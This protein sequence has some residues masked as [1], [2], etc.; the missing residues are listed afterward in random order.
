MHDAE[1]RALRRAAILLV[2]ISAAR[3]GW[4][5]VAGPPLG[6]DDESVLE[7][8]A[9]AVDDAVREEERRSAPLADG[10]LID[11]NRADEVELDRLPGI[12]PAIAGA[13]VQARADGLAFRRAEDLEAVRGVGPALVERIRSH[14]DLRRP[15]PRLRSD[16]V[17]GSSLHV[18]SDAVDLNRADATELERLPGIGPALAERIVRRRREQFFGSVSELL[19][20]PGIGPATLER[21]RPFVIVR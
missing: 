16:R 3:W 8:L 7:E 12:G 14:L 1:T 10:E 15:P 6:A 19:A 21:L 11:P 9:E 20:V 17:P 2:A 13:I 5:L 18:P 4:G